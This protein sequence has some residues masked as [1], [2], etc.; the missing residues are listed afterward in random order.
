MN[1]NPAKLLFS[2]LFSE[3]LE[4]PLSHSDFMIKGKEMKE[5]SSEF[6]EK[7]VEAFL[8]KEFQEFLDKAEKRNMIE[9]KINIQGMDFATMLE[10]VKSALRDNE[11]GKDVR[12]N[13]KLGSKLQIFIESIQ[14]FQDE[15][16]IA[17]NEKVQQFEKV[18]REIRDTVAGDRA[19]IIAQNTGARA[20]ERDS[21]T[22]GT[23]IEK[24]TSK[25]INRKLNKLDHEDAVDSSFT[26]R[27]D[28]YIESINSG[29]QLKYYE[30]S[31]GGEIKVT[32]NAP[33]IDFSKGGS[34]QKLG[35][36]ISDMNYDAKLWRTPDKGDYMSKTG[37]GRLFH[38]QYREGKFARDF[39]NI[40]TE[41][42]AE[43]QIW[44]GFQRALTQ[45]E[46]RYGNKTLAANKIS[47][48]MAKFINTLIPNGKTLYGLDKIPD[49][50]AMT[51]DI[52]FNLIA[53]NAGYLKI[54]RDH[55]LYHFPGD[56]FD[57]FAADTTPLKS[58]YTKTADSVA[59]ETD[60]LGDL[61]KD[62]D[63]LLL[64][65]PEVQ[66]LENISN[67]KIDDLIQELETTTVDSDGNKLNAEQLAELKLY[68]QDLQNN[69]N[70]YKR[71]FTIGGLSAMVF[72]SHHLGYR[73]NAG[74]RV[75]SETK[76]DGLGAGIGGTFW[77]DVVGN[78]TQNISRGLG[79]F[80][81]DYYDNKK[82][83]VGKNGL[84]V[85]VSLAY[86][87]NIATGQQIGNTNY[88]T[89]NVGF[90]LGVGAA[91]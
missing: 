66:Q 43:T 23:R 27:Y 31:T 3:H 61:S 45:L 12:K 40:P 87:A 19:T 21:L 11:S 86:N 59:F 53:K 58:L 76:V 74:Q 33:S 57:I 47:Q 89:W 30:A 72:A 60:S 71:N 52:L 80:A 20:N 55:G 84:N 7:K 44:E 39:R 51:P 8:V 85:G 68:A 73:N 65:H 32:E 1:L 64:K 36:L 37:V 70:L 35:F 69:R 4:E 62:Y 77:N 63:A 75:K 15:L 81:S 5:I 42:L 18:V 6:D 90:G 38:G 10:T 26:K 34:L 17:Q 79:I 91:E 29:S 16:Q 13:K 9:K 54:F 25:R 14:N 83:I 24:S 22:L 50:D 88:K 28:K 56:I 78:F 82:D 49:A 2:V 46:I 48:N 67:K 41:T